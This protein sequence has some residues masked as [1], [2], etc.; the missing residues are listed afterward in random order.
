MLVEILRCL[1]K[2]SPEQEMFVRRETLAIRLGCSLPT[3]TRTLA[4]LESQ[5]WI[6]RDQVKSRIRGFQVGSIALTKKAIMWL[7]FEP[8]AQK[9]QRCSPVIDACSS[10]QK[11]SLQ[12]QLQPA[13]GSV[14]KPSKSTTAV[15]AVRLPQ[16]LA[17]LTEHISPFGVCKLMKVAREKGLLLEDV[18]T[19][20]ATQIQQ[21]KNGFAYIRKLLGIDRDWHSQRQ[22]ADAAVL[23]ATAISVKKAA[24]EER[25]KNIENQ[26]YLG[27]DGFVRKVQRG[28]AVLYDLKEASALLGRNRGVCPIG[29]SFFDAIQDGRLTP[30]TA[31]AL[32]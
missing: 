8:S 17:W 1:S 13:A 27:H 20:C 18:T 15:G 32:G 25:V 2:E 30:W 22:E 29:E 3:I 24:L 12:R 28:V 21:A 5:G 9:A 11:Q 19:P 4:R 26:A 31:T 16:S 6:N 23:Q 10:F 7:G 14:D